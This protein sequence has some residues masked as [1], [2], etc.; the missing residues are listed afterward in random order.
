M[1]Y[2]TQALIDF[3]TAARLKLHDGYAWHQLV[4]SAFPQRDGAP[5]DFLTRLD[6]RERDRDFRLLILSPRP[7][8]CPDAWP[9]D[10][11]DAWQTR[12]IV[13]AFFAHRRYR[14]QLRANP[15][16]RDSATRKR[17]P[18]RT[19]DELRAW[20]DRKAASG[21]FAVDAE[22]LRIMQEGREW[23]RI[24]KR[25]TSGFH[26]AVE[27]DGMLTVTDRAEFAVALARGIGSA[28]AFGFGLL[29]LAPVADET[30]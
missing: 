27:F 13:P 29:A 6:R 15:T 24:E 5:R 19:D 3:E 7:P 8:Q 21:G 30:Q 1:S 18:L 11:P 16:R 10:R 17:L 22:T 26:H 9:T 20:L 23:F 28:K 2:L 25:G 12:E 14:F 4:W